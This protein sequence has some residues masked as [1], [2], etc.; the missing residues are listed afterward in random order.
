MRRRGVVREE[1]RSGEGGGEGG[2]RGL[3][4]GNWFSSCEEDGFGFRSAHPWHG[5]IRFSQ[6][7]TGLVLGSSHQVWSGLGLRTHGTARDRRRG[8]HPRGT[9][10]CRRAIPW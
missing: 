3:R 6:A 9:T 7:E 10:P 1:A 8:T 2:P 4:G 5:Q